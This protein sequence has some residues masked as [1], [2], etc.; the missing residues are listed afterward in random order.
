MNSAISSE[1]AKA[2]LDDMRAEGLAPSDE[3]VLTL[4]ALGRRISDGPETTAYNAPRFAIAGGVVFWEPTLAAFYFYRYASTFA[5]D[6]D[7]ADW[8]FAFACANGRERGYLEN[9]RDPE[10]IECAL[11][12]FLGSLTATKAEV[13]NAVCYAACGEGSPEPEKTDMTKAAEAAKAGGDAER[14]R[15]RRNYARLEERLAEAAAATGLTYEDIMIQTPSRLAGMIYAAHVKAGMQLTR[16][17]AKAN[18]DYLATRAAILKRL[19]AEK[20]AREAAK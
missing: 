10:E 20:A 19:R 12:N 14:E 17:S 3:D 13:D 18:A 8:L 11:G 9:L 2:D 5:D 7:T 4:H 6:E 1:L 16:T 15:E